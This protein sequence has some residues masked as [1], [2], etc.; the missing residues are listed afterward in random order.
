MPTYGIS[1]QGTLLSV[2]PD[3][4]YPDGAPQGGSITFVDI[5]ELTDLT[6][7]G[8]T[9]NMLE[10]TTHNEQDDR[11][12][13]GIRRHTE[14]SATVNFIPSGNATHDHLAGLQKKWFDGSRHI[15]KVTFPGGAKWVYSGFVANFEFQAPVDDV[16]TADVTIRPTG[17]HDW[18]Y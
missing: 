17:K 1:A 9:R 7:P 4:N 2:S 6:G 5:A 12:V 10:T 14:V 8:L 15:W 3:P 16:L 13:V 18:V 11:Y